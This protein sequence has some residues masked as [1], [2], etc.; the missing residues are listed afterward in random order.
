M[1]E[2]NEIRSNEANNN[3]D[4]TDKYNI[5]VN[6][7]VQYIKEQSMPE[8][9]RYVFAYTINI[10]NRGSVAVRLLSRHWLITDAEGKVQEVRGSGVVG[11]HP[12]LKPGEDF[13]YTSGA[14]I[15]TPVGSMQGSY[16]MQAGDGTTF[17]AEIA[18]FSL[19]QPNILH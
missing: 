3:S 5:A 14:I 7:S 8:K 9:K 10:L 16:Q 19:A 15:E 13:T 18:A 11:E 17:D 1:L 12:D 2:N 4:I 6:V